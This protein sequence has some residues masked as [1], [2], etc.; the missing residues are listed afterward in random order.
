VVTSVLFR[1]Y[2]MTDMGNTMCP[3]HVV[4]GTRKRDIKAWSL[5]IKYNGILK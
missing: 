5:L 2:G 3:R 1:N 4:A